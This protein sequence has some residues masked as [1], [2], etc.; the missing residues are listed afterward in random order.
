MHRHL[1]CVH[2]ATFIQRGHPDE[3]GL[4][5]PF[6]VHRKIGEQYRKCGVT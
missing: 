5:A 1:R 2:W 3:G 6:E 4:T